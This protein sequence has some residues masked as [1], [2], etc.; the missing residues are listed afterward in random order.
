MKKILTCIICPKG[1]TLAAE[2][3]D[4]KVSVSG[5]SCPKGAEYAENEVLHPMR[6]VTATVRVSNRP[7]T[8]VSVKTE[9]PV[10]KE[11]MQRV[12]EALR[13][14]QAEAP[15]EIG[16]VILPN[17]CGTSILATKSIP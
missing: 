17:L 12:M 9:N 3:T 4:G 5:H 1:C 16:D 7:D 15:L 13:Q 6:T 11:A 14:T 2:I 8:M 10:P